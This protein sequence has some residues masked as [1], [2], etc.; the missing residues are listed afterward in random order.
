MME[1][2]SHLIKDYRLILAEIVYHMPDRPQFL[3][4][5]I[6]NEMDI[7][8]RYPVLHSFLDYWEKNIEGKLHSV[9]VDQQR[10]ITPGEYKYAQMQ[11]TLQ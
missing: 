4:T 2:K 6:W 11:L 1:P 3:Q 9:Y 10:I 7:A 5:F 8:P